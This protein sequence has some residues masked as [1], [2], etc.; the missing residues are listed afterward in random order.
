MMSQ[1]IPAKKRNHSS[2]EEEEAFSC[3]KHLKL[4]DPCTQRIKVFTLSTFSLETET[5]SC[6]LDLRNEF[7]NSFFVSLKI[8]LI[9]TMPCDVTLLLSNGKRLNA[10]RLMLANSSAFFKRKI[11]Q[12]SSAEWQDENNNSNSSGNLGNFYTIKLKEIDDFKML[13]IC[14]DFIYSGGSELNCELSQLNELHSTAVKLELNELT[15]LCQ[16][17]QLRNEQEKL[18]IQSYKAAHRY[19]IYTKRFINQI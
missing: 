3:R 15:R 8:Y 14:I 2:P 12:L 13:K 19:T 6:P 11:D 5:D 16:L 7:M 1:H 4:N 18:R 10:H 9:K 17:I